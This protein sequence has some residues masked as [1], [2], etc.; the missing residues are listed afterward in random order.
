[1]I[2]VGVGEAQPLVDTSRRRVARVDLQIRIARP[3]R[4]SEL[5]QTP[6]QGAGETSA[7]RRLESEDVVEAREVALDDDLSAGDGAPLDVG[8]RE[9]PMANRRL[10]DPFGMRGAGVGRRAAL[11]ADPLGEVVA[12]DVAKYNRMGRGAFFGQRG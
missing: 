3:L 8:H 4:N 7:A 12:V 6:A 9:G 1:M 10:P 11:H 2:G 5:E